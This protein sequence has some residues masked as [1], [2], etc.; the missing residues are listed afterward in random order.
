MSIV[1]LLTGFTGFF[2]FFFYIF[3]FRVYRA[4]AAQRSDGGKKLK[5]SSGLSFLTSFR[6][7][8]KNKK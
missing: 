6:E 5:I 1:Y 3:S 7:V 2:G 4:I 8:R